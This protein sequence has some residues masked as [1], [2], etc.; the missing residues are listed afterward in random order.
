MNGHHAVFISNRDEARGF[1]EK[2][3]ASPPGIEYMLPK[4]V[5][6]CLKLKDIPSRAANLI[7]QEML[8]KGGEAAVAKNVAVG[9][10]S[11]DVLL[12]GTLRQYQL[13]IEK[14]KLQPFGLRTLA[15]EI[16]NI[17]LALENKSGN[18]KLPH[19]RVLEFGQKTLIM[20]IL[21][22]TPDS[23]TDGGRYLNTDAAVAHALEMKAEGAD[24][25]DVGGAS[26][27]PDSTMAAAEEELKRILPV[28]KKLAQEDIIISVDT[29][30]AEVARQ[31][32]SEGAHIINDIGGLQLDHELAGVL[33]EWQ[34]PA[35]LMHNRLQL[36]QGQPYFDLIADI[37][38]E[39]SNSIDTAVAAGLPLEQIIIDP[40][41][42][43]G[44]S[45]AENRLLIKNLQDFKSLGR[46]ILLGAS[47][48]TFIGRTLDLEV[49]ERLEGSLA[50]VALGI[51][52][53]A[54]I[55]RV[56]DVK[57]SKRV[58]QMTDAV[59]NEYG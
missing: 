28:I 5:F 17:L 24:I 51:M 26:S 58:A 12:L 8:A 56:H 30:R 14:L 22:V 43:F 33:A 39:L 37:I 27:R 4:A 2:I 50:A 16:E 23:F 49:E 25:I 40:G 55:V 47:R 54:D 3:G 38:A 34:S 31:A 48:K 53:G 41:L 21:N 6:R 32:L 18:L 15:A 7:K 10:G 57:Q 46:P 45:V 20:G 42:G 44:K 9:E 11:S 35:V 36:N 1:L 29:F 19:G 59:R 52:N 13:L